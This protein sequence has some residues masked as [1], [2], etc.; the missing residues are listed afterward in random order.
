MTS[1][2][3]RDLSKHGPR[4]RHHQPLRGI[5]S[6]EECAIGHPIRKIVAAAAG[7]DVGMAYMLPCYPGPERKADCPSYD[8]KTD[9]ERAAEE[10]ERRE[11]MAKTLAALPKLNAMKSKMIANGLETAK[12]S[13]PWCG[14]KNALQIICNIRGNQHMHARCRA[15]DTG[16]IE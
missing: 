16:I 4:C 15:C 2:S 7:T 6:G 1:S 12:A 3:T 14:E 9:A 8:P 5:Q 13:C 10:V 11:R